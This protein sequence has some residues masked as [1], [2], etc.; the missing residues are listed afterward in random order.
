MYYFFGYKNDMYYFK[1]NQ[2]RKIIKTSKEKKT[3]MTF[4]DP[5]N[6]NDF[7]ICFGTHFIKC[8]VTEIIWKMTN[9]FLKSKI[10]IVC[11]DFIDRSKRNNE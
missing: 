2:N 11:G 5:A 1:K 6:V 7:H 10:L 3:L 9:R 8:L 4:F